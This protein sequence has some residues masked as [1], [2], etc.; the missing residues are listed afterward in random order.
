MHMN[1][2]E[3]EKAEIATWLAENYGNKNDKNVSEANRD[4][5][6]TRSDSYNYSTLGPLTISV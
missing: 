2:E 3:T 4:R 6:G 1:T 5:K